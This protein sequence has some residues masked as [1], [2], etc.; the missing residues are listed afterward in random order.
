MRISL[1]IG[2]CV[3]HAMR[4]GPFYRTTLKRQRGAR[5]EKVF[6]RLRDFVT[7]MSKQTV[8]SHADSQTARDPVEHHCGNYRG[9]T[10]EPESSEGAEVEDAQENALTPI[11]VPFRRH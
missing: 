1:S 6:D 11:Y 2:V 10:P 9:P 8:I 3:V 4:G 7:P 5:Y